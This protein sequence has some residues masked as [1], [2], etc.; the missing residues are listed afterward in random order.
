MYSSSLTKD[1]LIEI[2]LRADE[3][4]ASNKIAENDAKSSVAKFD[5][6]N[7]EKPQTNTNYNL[8]YNVDDNEGLTN[9][10]PQHHSTGIAFLMCVASIFASGFVML[11]SFFYWPLARKW[12]SF[13][14]VYTWGWITTLSLW[15]TTIQYFILIIIFTLLIV[16]IPFAVLYFFLW[17]SIFKGLKIGRNNREIYAQKYLNQR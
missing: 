12:Y 5:S 17:R 7:E 1:K 16:G 14:S 3:V 11:G 13:I 6:R 8:V 10:A 9:Y 15:L 4:A 2:L